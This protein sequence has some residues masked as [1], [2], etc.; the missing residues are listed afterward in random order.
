MTSAEMKYEFEVRNELL[1]GLDSPDLEDA[2]INMFLNSA[3]IKIVENL[4]A[5]G[6]TQ[7]LTEL[8][9]TKFYSSGVQYTGGIENA[10][11]W[12]DNNLPSY[13]FLINSSMLLAKTMIPITSERIKCILIDKKDSFDFAETSKNSIW[14]EYPKIFIDAG[15][16]VGI[17][18]TNTMNIIEGDNQLIVNFI[19]KPDLIDV[20]DPING[21]CKLKEILHI[22]IV[23]EAVKQVTNTYK[24]KENIEE[25]E[26]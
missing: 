2:E 20:T 16:I 17:I 18:A 3:Q 4:Y 6:L 22:D 25:A 21:N 26:R 14:F 12:A 23:E 24:L 5:K 8:Y 9:I 19:K 13:M 15:Y 7:L 1:P 10:T 11:Q